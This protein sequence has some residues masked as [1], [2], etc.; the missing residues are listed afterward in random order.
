MSGLLFSVRGIILLERLCHRWSGLANYQITG[1]GWQDMSHP[2]YRVLS[3]MVCLNGQ[4]C[5]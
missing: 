2:E 1:E 3:Y 5:K 4:G